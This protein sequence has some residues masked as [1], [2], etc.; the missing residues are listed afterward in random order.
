VGLA[1]FHRVTVLGLRAEGFTKV[2]MGE[3]LI[4]FWL[5]LK[6]VRFMQRLSVH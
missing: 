4:G 5:G 1:D 2:R 6:A 3:R